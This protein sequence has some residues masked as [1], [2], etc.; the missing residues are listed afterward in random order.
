MR[1]SGVF[2]ALVALGVIVGTFAARPVHAQRLT[3]DAGVAQVGWL[4]PDDW[5]QSFGVHAHFDISRRVG[6]MFGARGIVGLDTQ[7]E[8]FISVSRR[9]RL[10]TAMLGVEYR[11]VEVR[12]ASVHLSAG[13]AT[14]RFWAQYTLRNGTTTDFDGSWGWVRGVYGARV[15][16]PV[17]ERWGV[18]VRSEIHPR[19]GDTRSWNPVF[20]VGV[21]F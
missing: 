15:F 2:A 18:H 1:K 8:G 17:T 3:L 5:G 20:A 4:I 6:V 9:E 12:K 16:M 19:Y 21:G 11:V 7:R 13:I 14:S 10:A